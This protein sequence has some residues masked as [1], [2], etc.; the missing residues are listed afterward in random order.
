MAKENKPLHDLGTPFFLFHESVLKNELQALASAC[1][2]Y[3][4]NYCVGYS[5]KT[6][7]LPPLLNYFRHSGISAEVV[8]EDEY[9]LALRVGFNPNRIIC[10][11]PVK[12]R[13]WI[14]RLLRL[15]SKLNID[16]KRELLYVSDY[17]EICD[18]E[19]EVG[20][21]VNLDLEPDFPNEYDYGISGSRFGFSAE[22]GELADA[23]EVLRK[24]PNIRLSGLHFHFNTNTRSVRLYKYIAEKFN[25]IS[26]IHNLTDL[27]YLDIGGGYFGGITDKPGWRDYM[28]AISSGL[29]S[30][31]FNPSNL[32]LILEPG[33]SLIAGSFSYFTKVVDVKKTLKQTFIVLNGSRIHIDP[34]MHKKSYFFSI[35]RNNTDNTDNDDSGSVS[36]QELVGFTCM[37]KDRF[38]VLKNFPPLIEGDIIQFE[39]VGAYTMTLSPLFIS[40]FP[41]VYV[42]K[43][44]G[45][46][47][48]IRQKWTVDEFVQL[49]EI[50]FPEV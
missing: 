26:V 29:R 16:S 6:N 23:I 3:W 15:K 47:D 21:R 19:L 38:F 31:R 10:N 32:T 5:V 1:E 46:L 45:N 4:D 13:S 37:E 22:N 48:C 33:V 35:I 39:K 9:D 8:S 2:R 34:L 24:S 20:L 42:I 11:G 43:E 40:F 7:S 27:K 17:A 28:K 44:N 30:T 18:E 50:K 14:Y 49:S 36:E 12:E 41:A 25:E